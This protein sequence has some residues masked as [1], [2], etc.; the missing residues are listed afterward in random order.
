MEII[1]IITDKND[2]KIETEKKINI[3]DIKKW[4]KGI[5][6]KFNISINLIIHAKNKSNWN[7]WLYKKQIYMTQNITKVKFYIIK[8]I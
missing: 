8:Q 7:G 5:L 4:E 6:V 3:K 2:N 1:N